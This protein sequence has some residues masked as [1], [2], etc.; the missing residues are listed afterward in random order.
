MKNINTH[1]QKKKRKK[2]IGK[3]DASIVMTKQNQK[4]PFFN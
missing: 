4:I 3:Q 2:P 1:T